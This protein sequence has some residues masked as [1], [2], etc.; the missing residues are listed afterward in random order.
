MGMKVNRLALSSGQM[1]TTQARLNDMITHRWRRLH[2]ST[3]RY[4]WPIHIIH[5][6][7]W[8]FLRRSASLFDRRRNRAASIGVRVKL[9]K[10]DTR[11]AKAT[12]TP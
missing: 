9:T 3:A 1:E 6:P 5:G 11:M 10:S 4:W 2:R 12:V 8:A 7:P